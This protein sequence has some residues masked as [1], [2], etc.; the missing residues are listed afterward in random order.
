QKLHGNLS[1]ARLELVQLM[2]LKQ[3]V[4]IS[5][6]RPDLRAVISTLPRPS[7]LD[8]KQLEFVALRHH[9]VLFENDLQAKILQEDTRTAMISLFPGLSLFA[10]RHYDDSAL[11]STNTWN[12][13]G[14]E[15]SWNLFA[16]PA[17]FQRLEA[18]ELAEQRGEVER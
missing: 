14:A 16:L 8:I 17:K 15:L 9:P 7:D 13:I 12:A 11:L 3:N 4:E 18:R 10:G 6:Q 2:G 5:L 1:T